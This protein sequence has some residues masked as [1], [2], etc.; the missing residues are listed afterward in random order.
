M[1]SDIFLAGLGYTKIMFTHSCS[2]ESGLL[3]VP[4]EV[5]VWIRVV[6]AMS[7][8]GEVLGGD[9]ARPAIVP[10]PVEALVRGV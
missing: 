1:N 4:V 3:A 8:G 7:G 2:A 9:D 10:P 5:D 6:E